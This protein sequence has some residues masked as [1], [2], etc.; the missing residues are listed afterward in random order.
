MDG[1]AKFREP[2]GVYTVTGVCLGARRR[3]RD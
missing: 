1:R 3:R 2:G